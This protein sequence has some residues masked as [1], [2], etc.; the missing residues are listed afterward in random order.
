[1]E[2][3][4]ATFDPGLRAVRGRLLWRLY[5]LYALLVIGYLIVSQIAGN[6]IWPIT[7][8]AYVTIITVPIAFVLLPIA[9][10]KRR[11]FGATL[12]IICALAF[13][14]ILLDTLPNGKN[15]PAPEGA[16]I[17]TAL[18]YNIGAG[19]APVDELIPM[20]RESGADVVALVEVN[21]DVASAIESDLSDLYPYRV[22]RGG[23]IP[24]KALLSRF[25]ISSH[26]WL[27]FNPGRPDLRADIDFE[28]SPIT[29]VVAHPPPPEITATGVEDRPGTER[30]IDA[31]TALISGTET[32]TLL[33]GDFNIT[34]QHDEYVAIQDAGMTDAFNEAG[35]GFGF[36]MPARLQLF[37]AVSD[38]LASIRI[39]PLARIDYI[40]AS[41]AWLPLDAWVGD[42]A[43]SD[44][45]PVLA[46]LALVP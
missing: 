36:T 19:T 15:P 32:P 6:A 9:L 46:R 35:H 16:K 25:P 42:D 10:W 12:Q 44:H 43:G 13:I 7:V 34:R 14:W 33:L 4:D 39:V 30:Q 45:L 8:F 3:N 40:W 24:G 1:M 26:E 23:G 21:D 38:R 28:G 5:D 11:W 27:E 18:T 22:V 31:L 41:D 17:L 37:S 2:R 29:V 20:L